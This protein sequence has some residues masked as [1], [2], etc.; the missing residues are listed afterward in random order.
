MA[1]LQ[2][3]AIMVKKTVTTWTSSITDKSESQKVASDNDTTTNSVTVTKRL[4]ARSHMDGIN[5]T[6]SKINTLFKAKTKPFLDGGWNVCSIED[7]PELRKELTELKDEFEKEVQDFC[8]RYDTVRNAEV[9][10]LGK[11][12]HESEYPTKEQISHRFQC[13]FA[14]LPLPSVNEDFRVGNSD[15]EN[16]EIRKEVE[17]TVKS[18]IGNTVTSG[19]KEMTEALKRLQE[20]FKTVPKKVHE[21][22][23][24]NVEEL[25]EVLPK[26]NIAG[27]PALDKMMQE[28]KEK[29]CKYGTFG[30]KG[31]TERATKAR[32]EVVT[33]SE[34]LVAQIEERMA[35]YY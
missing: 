9:S 34:E 33:A 18:A 14:V 5:K 27:D 17:A 25:C 6:V 20:K 31:E 32:E 13:G 29:V 11:L 19:L 21:S 2:Q 26:L 10:K 22:I 23:I 4:I 16:A 24:G 1:N 35:G 7:W 28:I 8:N 3:K 12:G 15:A 30:L